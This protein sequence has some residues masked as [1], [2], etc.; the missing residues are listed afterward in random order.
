M[1]PTYVNASHEVCDAVAHLDDRHVPGGDLLGGPGGLLLG[2]LAVVLLF[3][4]RVVLPRAEVLDLHRPEP[5]SGLPGPSAGDV[6]RLAGRGVEPLPGLLV[7]VDPVGAQD[8][9]EVA[10]GGV[11]APG[12]VHVHLWRCFLARIGNLYHM[13]QLLNWQFNFRIRVFPRRRHTPWA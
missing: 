6:G 2:L 3:Q 4:L 11:E 5:L 1:I 8:E 7:E 9:D 12:G 13:L 10:A